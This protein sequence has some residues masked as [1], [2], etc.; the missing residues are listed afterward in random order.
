M[1]GHWSQIRFCD[2]RDVWTYTCPKR[3]I[4]TRKRSL[5][6]GNIFAPVC[7]S[8]HRGVVSQHALQVGGSPGPHPGGK[9]GGLARGGVSRPTP[10]RE[11]EG[12]GQ[13]G[14]QAHTHGGLQ[15]QTRRISRPT[16]GGE[17]PSQHMGVYPS[18]HWDTHPTGVHSC[19]R[20]L[21]SVCL[22]YTVHLFFYFGNWWEVMACEGAINF[23]DFE[24]DPRDL[25]QGSHSDWKNWKTWKNG[26][27]FSSQG[28]VREFWTDWKSQGKPHQI[29]ENWGNFRKKL[30]V[31]F[32][33]FLNELCI[34]RKMDKVF[35]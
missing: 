31:I 5:G 20:H 11:V 2:Y 19:F 23:V 7:H 28:K 14:L 25:I 12:S 22:P 35:S 32:Q 24:R 18:M 17:S 15:T 13:G 3:L 1:N 16:P 33:W 30:F 21:N 8:V 26:K 6:Q 10:R 29:L 34:I 4:T 9:L 27:A